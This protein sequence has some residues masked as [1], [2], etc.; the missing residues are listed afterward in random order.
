MTEKVGLIIGVGSVGRRHVKVMAARYP[1]LIVV[2]P[3]PDAREWVVSEVSASARCFASVNESSRFLRQHSNQITAVVANWGPD[4]VQTIQLLVSLGIRRIV[5]EK[6]LANSLQAVVAI[7]ELCKSSSLLL[8]MGFHL[9]YRGITDFVRDTSK[10]ELGGLPTSCIV[11]G[12]ARC[13]S[14]S[15]SHWLDLAIDV[16]G[17][18]PNSVAASLR[19]T[20]INPRSESLQYWDGVATWSF[21]TGHRLTVC[22]DNASS[23][24]ETVRFYCHSGILEIDPELNVRAFAR[25]PAELEADPRLVRV[26]VV[27]R[28]QPVAEFSSNFQEVLTEQ[29]DEVEGLRPP[30]YT[31]KEIIDSAASLVA[32]FESSRLGRQ[33]S[34]PPSPEVIAAG[35]DWAI[36]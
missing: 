21:P 25:N 5:C 14:T 6:P 11:E 29:L 12:G 15:G 17:E 24:H 23:V 18:P 22:Y 10:H 27:Q 33:I 3:S 16:F 28:K 9:R 26:G 36:S 7:E 32:A 1:K 31:V 19:G 34:L 35:I 2:D 30:R 4:H 20:S 13:I 8:A